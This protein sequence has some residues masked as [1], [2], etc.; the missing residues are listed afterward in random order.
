MF[1][2][3]VREFLGWNIIHLE[4]DAFLEEHFF[5]FGVG[6]EI[7]RVQVEELLASRV[8]DLEENGVFIIV[9][10]VYNWKVRESKA[11]G[12]FFRKRRTRE[13]RKCDYFT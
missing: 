7:H 9:I 1:I 2:D 12:T 3:G 10:I 6:R 4:L 13:A 5:L 11:D 8:L